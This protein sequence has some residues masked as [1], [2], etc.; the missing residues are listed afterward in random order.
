MKLR[1]D[2]DEVEVERFRCSAAARWLPRAL[3]ASVLASAT[4]AAFR[5]D[6]EGILLGS[7]WLRNGIALA[8]A[9]VALWIVRKGGETR[10]V[11]GID[12]EG[13][14]LSYGS[15]SSKLPFARMSR[16]G[17]AAPFAA[18][19]NWLPAMLVWD[20]HKGCWRVLALLGEGDRLLRTL[21]ARAGREDL[22][23][24]AD[25]LKLEKRMAEAGRRVLIGYI[26]SAVILAAGLLYRFHE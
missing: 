25:S 1:Q 6:P 24:W 16:L 15:R 20:K 26:I 10:I 22:A 14:V 9:L 3:A 19:R 13:L 8:G 21:L 18:T 7:S 11:A 4:L 17:Y 12:D 5:M 23:A 2:R